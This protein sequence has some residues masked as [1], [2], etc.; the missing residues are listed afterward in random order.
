MATNISTES[1]FELIE[2]SR[3]CKSKAG[4]YANDLGGDFANSI[5]NEFK[6][7]FID[8]DARAKIY[9]DKSL[10][11]EARAIE[12][13]A[14]IGLSEEDYDN[15]V[16]AYFEE[17]P[18]NPMTLSQK[19]YEYLIKGADLI[20]LSEDSNPDNKE[21][22]LAKNIR[23]EVSDFYIGKAEDYGNKVNDAIS[24]QFESVGYSKQEREG[25][26]KF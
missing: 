3:K 4:F 9:A 2:Q 1:V 17:A 20:N 10:E 24:K 5:L 7:R 13:V 26:R 22:V 21:E 14:K 8:Y 6:R 25:L 11:C 19:S 15:L 12:L 18:E 16:E 23:K